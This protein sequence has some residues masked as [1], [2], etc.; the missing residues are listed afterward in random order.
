MKKNSRFDYSSELAEANVDNDA[1]DKAEERLQRLNER[2]KTIVEEFRNV[3][4]KIHTV[5]NRVNAMVS[6]VAKIDASL[7]RLESHFPLNISTEDTDRIHSDF[8]KIANEA[9]TDI[10][11]EIASA[12]RPAQISISNRTFWCMVL[13]LVLALAWLIVFFAITI[14]AN[15]YLI[16]SPHLTRI[17]I[18]FGIAIII[19][20][21]SVTASGL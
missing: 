19:S 10:R 6:K 5:C 20:L 13:V 8:A 14:F 2:N 3:K 9:L 15:I 1:I 21:T 17:L 16:H 12:K 18:I 11:K 7:T 4:P